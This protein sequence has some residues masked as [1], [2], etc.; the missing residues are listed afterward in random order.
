MFSDV[1]GSDKHSM[2]LN[3]ASAG[4]FDH[5][6]LGKRNALHFILTENILCMTL[7]QCSRTTDRI[8][9][10]QCR[11]QIKSTWQITAPGVPKL[12]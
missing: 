10:S 12:P 11:A 1:A 3:A 4:L 6:L 5:A 2:Q 9:L 8:N 7:L